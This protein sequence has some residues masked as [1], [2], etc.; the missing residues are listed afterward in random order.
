MRNILVSL[1]IFG[2]AFGENIYTDGSSDLRACI[3]DGLASFDFPCEVRELH[4]SNEI[5]ADVKPTAPKSVVVGFKEKQKSGSFTVFCEIKS[6]T[7]VLTK[8]KEC[9]NKKV[10][11][12]TTMKS[13]PISDKDADF[14]KEAF[15]NN[16]RGLM[17]GMVNG[18]AVRG[19]EIKPIN[20]TTFL[21][22][23]DFLKVEFS[24][25]YQSGTLVGYVGKV[26]NLS[27]YIDK[28]IVLHKIMQKGWVML[29]IDGMR[30]K[31]IVLRPQ[32]E[33][34][35]YLIALTS[36]TNSLYPVKVQGGQ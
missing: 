11:I 17:A 28:K 27:K 22:D 21:N 8:G 14:S 20:I 13:I 34:S 7:V 32:E 18:K 36:G 25:L 2:V 24:T 30:D 10:V 16:A 6:Y 35:I 29:Y 9:E 5:Q 1:A 23:D 19:Y 15:L 31:E 26:K 3:G 4:F 12:D 33:R